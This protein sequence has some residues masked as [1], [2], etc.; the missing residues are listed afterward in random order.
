MYEVQW[1]PGCLLPKKEVTNIQREKTKMIEIGSIG[2][3]S[4]FSTY[5]DGYRNTHR[6]KCVHIHSTFSPALPTKAW[7]KQYSN[8]NENIYHPDFNSTFHQEQQGLTGEMATFRPKK[9]KLKNGHGT[10]CARKQRRAQR[11]RRT[12]QKS[13]R[14]PPNWLLLIKAGTD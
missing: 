2:V 6:H 7:R 13:K 9:R 3:N 10:S 8:T 11:M 14:A 5:T 1:E 12:G 4:H